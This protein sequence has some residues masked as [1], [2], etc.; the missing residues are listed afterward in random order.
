MSK[1]AE[2]PK[3]KYF[4]LSTSNPAKECLHH[5]NRMSPA[6]NS[7]FFSKKLKRIVGGDVK[8]TS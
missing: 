7:Y 1:E 6:S 4:S 3:E 8:L 5:K 2:E